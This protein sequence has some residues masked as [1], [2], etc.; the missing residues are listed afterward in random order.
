MKKVNTK[1]SNDEKIERVKKRKIL[2]GLILFFGL[3]TLVLSI[4]SLVTNF[5][6]VLAI[7][8]F[9]IEVILSSYRNKL[10]PK[11]EDLDSKNQ[12]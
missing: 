12:E 1:I 7:L 10:D 2:K 5:T 11:V 6:P 4:H 3:L 9:L 8:A